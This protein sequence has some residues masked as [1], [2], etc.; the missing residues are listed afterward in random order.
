VVC[1][2]ASVF[3]AT[4]CAGS[5]SF[6]SSRRFIGK[7]RQAAQGSDRR[8]DV[9]DAEGGIEGLDILARARTAAQ[10]LALNVVPARGR[11]CLTSSSESI[12]TRRGANAMRLR[13]NPS[14]RSKP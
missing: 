7:V 9:L 1:A 2:D 5:F 11:I 8:L 13:R 14:P 12:S 3:F 10:V 6:R 4:G